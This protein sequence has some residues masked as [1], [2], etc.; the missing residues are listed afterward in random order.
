[1]VFQYLLSESKSVYLIEPWVG[2][3]LIIS[4]REHTCHIWNVR[5]ICWVNVAQL[6]PHH[7]GVLQYSQ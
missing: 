2:S 7:S 4:Y 1:M 5:L 6:A 3:I